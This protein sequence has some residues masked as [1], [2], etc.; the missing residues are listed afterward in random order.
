MAKSRSPMSGVGGGAGLNDARDSMSL[1]DEDAQALD[2]A[3]IRQRMV[4]M[5]GYSSASVSGHSWRSATSSKSGY[6][7]DG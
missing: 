4:D 2:F 5:G 7:S 3:E 1:S 6:Y